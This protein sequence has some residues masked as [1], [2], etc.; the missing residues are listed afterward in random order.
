MILSVHPR[1]IS[2]P[3]P[4]RNRASSRAEYEPARRRDG[5]RIHP[6]NSTPQRER[7]RGQRTKE[8]DGRTRMFGRSPPPDFLYLGICMM[9]LKGS[10]PQSDRVPCGSPALDLGEDAERKR[11]MEVAMCQAGL[12]FERGHCSVLIVTAASSC[13]QC[14]PTGG[15]PRVT[16]P[17][18]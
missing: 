12:S 4:D 8:S 18:A 2:Q 1:S 13:L 16:A 17:A 3:A 10:P 14:S 6:F 7:E 11:E 9:G 5:I 15:I